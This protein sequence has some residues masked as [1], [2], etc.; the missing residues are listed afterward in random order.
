MF[1]RSDLK[2]EVLEP[3][4]DLGETD[5]FLTLVTTSALVMWELEDFSNKL[6]EL[7]QL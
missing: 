4:R 7:I 6:T 5:Q 1:F 2:W 3:L